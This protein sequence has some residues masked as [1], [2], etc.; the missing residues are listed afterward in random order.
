M[1]MKKI[2]KLGLLTL[3]FVLVVT[4]LLASNNEITLASFKNGKITKAA[5]KQR[6]NEIPSFYRQRIKSDKDKENFLD[7]MIVET[8]F[9]KEAK[10]LGYGDSTSVQTESMDRAKGYLSNE[11]KKRHI[12]KGNI[13]ISS[14]EKQD[15]FLKHSKDKAYFGKTFKEAEAS[16]ETKLIPIKQKE[17]EDK[18]AAKIEKEYNIKYNDDVIN[19]ISIDIPAENNKILDEVIVKSSDED[20]RKTVKDF[21][22]LYKTLPDFRKASIKKDGLKKFISNLTRKDLFYKEALKEGIDKDPTIAKTLDQY[23]KSSI[24]NHYYHNEFMNKIPQTDKDIKKYYDDNIANFSSKPSRKIRALHFKDQKN[25]KKIRKKIA[26]LVK[27]NKEDKIINLMKKNKL[28]NANDGIIDHIYKNGIVPGF[29]KDKVFADK[30]WSV[31]PGQVSDTFKD[32]KGTYTFFYIVKDNPAEPTPFDES[33]DKIKKTMISKE[34]KKL[35]DKRKEELYKEF[36]V[37]VFPDKIPDILPAKDYFE[38]AMQA[39]NNKRFKDALFY[40]DKIIKYYPNKKDDYK[41]LFMKGFIYSEDLNDKDKAL[42]LFKKVINDFP[43]AELH[44]SAQYMINEIEG[45]NK[46]AEKIKDDK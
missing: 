6:L 24:L 36:N 38:R 9:Y 23:T 7:N 32:S 17:V 30:I 35:F 21:V 2:T 37:K 18:L 45:G 22:D 1:N 29:G 5:F 31:K 20:L 15:Y 14:K 33:K 40:Y 41:A 4:S 3:M 42:E 28:D 46:T 43:K 26:K 44:E 10:R 34:A 12:S 13:K 27:K 16:I 25:A 39:Q 8:I 11:Y 19:K